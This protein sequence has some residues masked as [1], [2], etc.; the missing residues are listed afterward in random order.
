MIFNRDKFWQ[1]MRTFL[2]RHDRAVTQQRVNAIN[3]LLDQFEQIPAWSDTRHIA[4]A[5]ATIYIE[6]AYTFEPIQEFG[7]NSYF[8]RRYG[9]N[10]RKGRE[11]G[12]DA[13]GEGAKYSGKGYVQLTGES[14]YEKMEAKL[15]DKLPNE[16]LKFERETGQKFDLTD[17]ANQAKSPR[18][19]F[20]IMTVGMF[21]GTFTGKAFRHYFTEDKSDW[22]NARRIINGTDRA[23]EIANYAVELQSVL[24]RAVMTPSVADSAASTETERVL[25]E[26]MVEDIQRRSDDG[27]EGEKPL[28]MD[29]IAPDDGVTE[30]DPTPA[31]P[32]TETTTTTTVETPQGEA[33]TETV[34]TNEQPLTEK[35][36][37]A[38]PKE[39]STTAA[40][41]ITIGGFSIAALGTIL[42]GW[43]AQGQ[44][45]VK[46][47]SDLILKFFTENTR[48]F[49]YCVMGI[50]L[51]ILVKKIFKQITFLVQLIINANPRLHDIKIVPQ[52]SPSKG[53]FGRIFG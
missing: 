14:N 46:A 16:V 44:I 43:L 28:E 21:E 23:Q 30:V 45:D 8:E 25:S 47:T 40:T 17:Y 10:T 27:Q 33:K 20:L 51:I 11:L 48:Y 26:Q 49:F 29:V 13:P 19:A 35:T 37:E 6:T 4:Y 38:P 41:G 42:Q 52:E 34:Q 7:S 9:S 53:F 18:I 3:F 12:N 22:Y 15:R 5:L 36:Q 32:A 39:G 1:G 2:K 50:I 24:N 31:P